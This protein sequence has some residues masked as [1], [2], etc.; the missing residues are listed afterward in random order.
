[1]SIGYLSSVFSRFAYFIMQIG[2]D[3]KAENE[4]EYGKEKRNSKRQNKNP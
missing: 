3:K 2:I 1:M 4:A